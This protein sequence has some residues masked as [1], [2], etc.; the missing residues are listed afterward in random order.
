MYLGKIFPNK[1][2]TFY[3]SKFVKSERYQDFC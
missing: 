1:M 3:F 2:R